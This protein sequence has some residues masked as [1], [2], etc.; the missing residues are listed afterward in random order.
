[1]TPLLFRLRRRGLLPIHS[2]AS[3][4]EGRYNV[5]TLVFTK[6]DKPSASRRNAN[7]IRGRN[8]QLSTLRQVN[9]ERHER[10]RMSEFTN[11]GNHSLRYITPMNIG[12]QDRTMPL[13]EADEETLMR[14]EKRFMVASVPR[15]RLN[16]SQVTQPA[17]D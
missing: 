16:Q 8:P 5:V 9:R 2:E 3:D 15:G 6:H 7:M 13:E 14:R 4:H 1:M 10:R 17:S 11:V 12:T